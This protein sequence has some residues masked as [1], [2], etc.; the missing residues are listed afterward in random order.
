MLQIEFPMMEMIEF[1][2]C[3]LVSPLI[4]EP[5]LKGQGSGL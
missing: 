5:A 2:L 3:S 4:G 1:R